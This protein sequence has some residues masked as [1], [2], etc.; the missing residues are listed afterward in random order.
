M[1]KN[2]LD[3]KDIQ[4]RSGYEAFS[5]IKQLPIAS[6]TRTNSNCMYLFVLFES[7]AKASAM[8]VKQPSLRD[9][10]QN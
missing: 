4:S 7:I 10:R 9:N 5:L 6:V 2:G 1:H 8:A 3:S